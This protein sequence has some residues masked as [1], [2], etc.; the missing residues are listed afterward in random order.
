MTEKGTPKA[1]GPYK[2]Q[3]AKPDP[4][5]PNSLKELFEYVWR[6]IDKGEISRGVAFYSL[7]W[8][9]FDLF[10]RCDNEEARKKIKLKGDDIDR[11][12][13]DMAV[14]KIERDIEEAQQSFGKDA[15]DFMEADTQRRIRQEVDRS[16][17]ATVRE[18]TSGW[19]TFGTN[20]A[21]GV[22]AGLV[23]AAISLFLYFVVK[24]DPSTNA[25]GKETVG[26]ERPATTAPP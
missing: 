22:V 6:K 2:E 9:L 3:P 20:V 21:A 16:I 19:K 8:L 13:Q 7:G 11:F 24:Y 4:N 15:F 12:V 1:Y 5:V 23:L 17:V 18:F 26:H 10:E 14:V 25:I